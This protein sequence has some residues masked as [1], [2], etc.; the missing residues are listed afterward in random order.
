MRSGSVLAVS[1]VTQQRPSAWVG[2]VDGGERMAAVQWT[3][4]G[5]QQPT[6][7]R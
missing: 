6:G 2:M 7:M 3:V 4:D 5:Q 1:P